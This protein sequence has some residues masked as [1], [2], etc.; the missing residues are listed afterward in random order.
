VSKKSIVIV[1]LT[2][3]LGNQLFQL[4]AGIATAN[5]KKLYLCSSFGAPRK[6]L[7]GNIELLNFRLPS[8]INMITEKPCS[9]LNRKV[10]GYVLRIGVSPKG[11]ESNKYFSWIVRSIAVIPL[12][13]FLRKKV[14]IINSVGVGYSPITIKAK[15]TLLFGY[16]QSFRWTSDDRVKQI[17]QK[18]SLKYTA[19]KI[20]DYQELSSQEKP[21][22]VHIRLGDYLSEKNFGIPSKKYYEDG[23]SRVL[24]LGKC[25]SIWLFSDQLHLARSFLPD[26]LNVPIRVIDEFQESPAATLE[27]MRLGIGY[28]IANSTFSWW[29]AFLRKHEDAEVIAPIPWFSGMPEPVDLIPINWHRIDS[30]FASSY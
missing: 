27:V 12:S 7:N 25:K 19:N 20:S 14:S 9:L 13:I 28:V 6:S 15:A 10:S 30:G 17:M 16:F 2:G 21:L 22:V 4:A 3:G 18:I 1:S 11:F 24:E 5:K 29:A 26:N 23:I 8:E